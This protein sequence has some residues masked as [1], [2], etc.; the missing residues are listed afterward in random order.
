MSSHSMRTQTRP[1]KVQRIH[2]ILRSTRLSNR[3]LT[4]TTESL[5]RIGSLTSLARG[6][7]PRM[8]IVLR[9]SSASHSAPHL[10]SFQSL[11]AS[12]Q[13]VSYQRMLS[14]MGLSIEQL[15]RQL[16]MDFHLLARLEHTLSK[17]TSSPLWTL[18]RK[19]ALKKS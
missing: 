10:I 1:T 16:C 7:L 6:L 3:R 8:I 2:T 17:P 14:I 18:S 11:K 4:L 9:A 15:H 19:L 5:R 12:S 13:V